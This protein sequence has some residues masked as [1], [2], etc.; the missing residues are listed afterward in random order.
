MIY[1]NHVGGDLMLEVKLTDETILNLLLR[2]DNSEHTGNSLILGSGSERTAIIYNDF[3]I[4]KMSH[5]W[6]LDE[7]TPKD[8]VEN[9]KKYNKKC[10]L[11][12]WEGKTFFVYG[13]EQTNDELEITKIVPMD[14]IKKYG[15]EIFMWGNWHGH[16]VTFCERLIPIEEEDCDNE[17]ILNEAKDLLYDM[18]REMKSYPIKV[19][20]LHA[21]N[22]G[23]TKDGKLKF[24]DLGYWKKSNNGFYV[25]WESMD[26]WE[27]ELNY[28]P[29]RYCSGDCKNCHHNEND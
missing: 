8:W 21:Q 2:A 23:R 19:C 20:D 3:L 26:Y 22:F 17:D 27:K 6:Q 12:Q 5:W 15:A 7:N 16:I 28:D 24:C 9:N 1:Y 13:E 4:A 25:D 11:H 18:E 10:T 29:C 14:I